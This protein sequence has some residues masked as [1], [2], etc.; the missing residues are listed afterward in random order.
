MKRYVQSIGIDLATLLV[1]LVLIQGMFGLLALHPFIQFIDSTNIQ[2]ITST[3][4]LPPPGILY[5]G[6]ALV[7]VLPFILL[8]GLFLLFGYTRLVLYN[9][10]EKN[11][12]SHAHYWRLMLRLLGGFF[13]IFIPGLII[14]LV[15]AA[16]IQLV[17]WIWI[18]IPIR[19]ALLAVF[20]IVCGVFFHN[21]RM[22]KVF[23]SFEKAICSLSKRRLVLQ[24]VLWF[25]IA[26]S[27]L[28]LVLSLIKLSDQYW[29]FTSIIT[30]V[31]LI[32]WLRV[33]I[34][35]TLA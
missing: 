17:P 4:Q 2:Q 5:S 30:A 7:F 24:G 1:F 22:H 31:L 23:F 16:I 3:D 21:I 27:A 34:L 32:G 19:W 8:L 13:L 20:L 15:L 18:T 11:T 14:L 6:M 35:D 33:Y 29:L 26:N 9:I 25:V 12:Y 28:W 10:L